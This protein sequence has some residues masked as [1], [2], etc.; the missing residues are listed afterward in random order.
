MQ[1]ISECLNALKHSAF[2]LH[3]EKP[4]L[5]SF[6]EYRLRNNNLE[7][8]EIEYS[9]FRIELETIFKYYDETSETGKKSVTAVKKVPGKCTSFGAIPL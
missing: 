6:L 7:Q 8:E 2:W 4:S 5:M 1:L 3:S 9:R